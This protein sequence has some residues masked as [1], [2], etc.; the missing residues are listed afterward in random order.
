MEKT[1]STVYIKIKHHKIPTEPSACQWQLFV[2]V[3]YI[4]GCSLI[5]IC[6]DRYSI[7]FSITT[8]GT[9]QTEAI[10]EI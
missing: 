10:L 5:R 9:V 7:F 4:D 3:T 2:F 1:L 6:T 8:K